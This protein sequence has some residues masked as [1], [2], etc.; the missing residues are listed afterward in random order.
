MQIGVPTGQ[1]KRKSLPLRAIRPAVG[2]ATPF[3]GFLSG[4]L[5]HI[6]TTFSDSHAW[7]RALLAAG[8]LDRR[9][10]RC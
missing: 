10:Q 2:A 1:R 5:Q 6:E 4:S 9:A 7:L 8:N 3:V